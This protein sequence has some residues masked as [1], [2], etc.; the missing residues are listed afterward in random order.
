MI[1]HTIV[2][3]LIVLAL[4]VGIIWRRRS[5]LKSKRFFDERSKQVILKTQSI[6]WKVHLGILCAL[7]LLVNTGLD[8]FLLSSTRY[9]ILGENPLQLCLIGLLV[10]EIIIY[11]IIW[12]TQNKIN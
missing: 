7:V 10:V 6:A 11:A 12:K 8:R 1:L 9:L 5:G 3:L 4:V 2:K